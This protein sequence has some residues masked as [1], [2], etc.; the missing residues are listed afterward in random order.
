MTSS[1]NGVNV[2]L[3]EETELFLFCFRK[4]TILDGK[5]TKVNTI[6]HKSHKA[7]MEMQLLRRN[8]DASPPANQEQQERELETLYVVLPP[9]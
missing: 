9:W 6:S 7:L 8:T 3:A 2:L 1:Q 5:Q 4:I